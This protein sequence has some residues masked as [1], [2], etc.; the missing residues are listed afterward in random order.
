MQAMSRGQ[1][2][3]GSRERG[4]ALFV[5]LV[6][7]VIMTILGLSSVQTT[8]LEERMSRNARD[9]NLAFQAA[10]SAAIDAVAEI[11]TWV[12][13]G[14]FPNAGAGLYLAA[15][16][17]AAQQVWETVDWTLASQ[18]AEAPSDIGGLFTTPKYIVERITENGTDDGSEMVQT[19]YGEDTG[20]S[21][22][23]IYRI[24]TH[25]T[26]GTEAAR[27]MIQ[28]TYGRQF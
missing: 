13:D 23:I 28:V 8:S 16:P 18:V 22:A 26:G 14:G 4:A 15:A 11:E 5:S 20:G 7:L 21:S 2:T 9:S 24:T 27:V 17:G 1:Y 3:L 12:A 10:E 25:G 6:M 19:N